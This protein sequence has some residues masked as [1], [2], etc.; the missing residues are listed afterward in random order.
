MWSSVDLISFFFFFLWPEI[1]RK[2]GAFEMLFGEIGMPGKVGVEAGYGR[3]PDDVR[4]DYFV[5]SLGWLRFMRLLRAYRPAASLCVAKE[6]ALHVREQHG[7]R[8]EDLF[9]RG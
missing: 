3:I 6:F 9:L 4:V 8:A 2:S 7:A 1:R 5:R